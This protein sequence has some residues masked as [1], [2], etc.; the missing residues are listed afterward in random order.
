MKSTLKT[1]LAAM[2]RYQNVEYIFAATALA[3]CAA[4]VG[5]AVDIVLIM[6]C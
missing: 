2:R 5:I 4:L 1:K 6:C 3:G